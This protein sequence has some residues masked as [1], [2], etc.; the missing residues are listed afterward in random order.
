[1]AAS[2]FA[3]LRDYADTSKLQIAYDRRRRPEDPVSTETVWMAFH[4]ARWIET[5]R[6][7]PIARVFE[8]H[9]LPTVP[10]L[11]QAG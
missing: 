5:R 11:I 7:A 2:D 1:M 8:T 9:A 10:E 4:L 6:P 3:A